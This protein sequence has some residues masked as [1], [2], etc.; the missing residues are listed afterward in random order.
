MYWHGI[1]KRGKVGFCPAFR[2]FEMAV[3]QPVVL[4]WGYEQIR[5]LPISW[6]QDEG[7]RWPSLSEAIEFAMAMR[8]DKAAKG[9]YPW[10]WT[11]SGSIYS[12]ATINTMAEVLY[13]NTR[14]ADL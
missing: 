12:P 9:L 11:S 2:R 8:Y 5:P 4:L 10:I 7:E 13:R 1:R 14:L 6:S 3:L